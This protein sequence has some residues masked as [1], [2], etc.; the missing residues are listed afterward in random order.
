MRPTIN[1][2]PNYIYIY[3]YIYLYSPNINSYLP[4]TKRISVIVLDSWIQDLLN[5]ASHHESA[6]L[7]SKL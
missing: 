4:E 6:G 7:E 1:S 5:A 2:R 3:I